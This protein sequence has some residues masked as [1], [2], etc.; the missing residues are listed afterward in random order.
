M[1]IF[2]NLKFKAE[3]KKSPDYQEQVARYLR[4]ADLQK[5][6][7]V[8][9]V[10]HCGLSQ[11]RSKRVNLV[12]LMDKERA[13]RYE[14]RQYRGR[15]EMIAQLGYAMFESF[16]KWHLRYYGTRWSQ[17]YLVHTCTQDDIKEIVRLRN[18]G[19]SL[20]NIE[21]RSGYNRVSCRNFLNLHDEHGDGCFV[22]REMAK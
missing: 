4:K 1:E 7:R 6:R 22:P 11:Y 8:D 15:A 16:D 18:S 19:L 2:K 3:E 14:A 9:L 21:R 12:A 5:L 13:C 20:A 17:V 10:K